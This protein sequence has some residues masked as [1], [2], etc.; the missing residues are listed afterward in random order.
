MA[1][2]EACGGRAGNPEDYDPGANIVY[3]SC[4]G[5]SAPQN[6]GCTSVAASTCGFC[7]GCNSYKSDVTG[8]V[9]CY[10]AGCG[11]GCSSVPEPFTGSVSYTGISS[12]K[13]AIYLFPSLFLSILIGIATFAL[14]FKKQ[15]GQV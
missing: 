7:P 8:T 12:F 13:S 4:S 5:C 3:S 11:S 2:I 14:Y 1:C 10:D 15:G 9:T 6:V